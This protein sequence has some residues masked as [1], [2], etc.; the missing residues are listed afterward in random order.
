VRG[1][2]EEVW[3][4]RGE[5]GVKERSRERGK[6]EEGR[7]VRATAGALAM[8]RESPHLDRACPHS[9]LLVFRKGKPGPHLR[10][11]NYQMRFLTMKERGRRR[12]RLRGP[13][14]KPRCG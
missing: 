7:G 3:S 13:D 6:R 11:G 4:E 1:A 14:P 2:S 12:R 10:M 9:C 8:S 5:G